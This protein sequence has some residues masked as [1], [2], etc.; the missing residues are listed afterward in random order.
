[1]AI[2]PRRNPE[3]EY[4]SFTF[5][6]VEGDGIAE[7]GYLTVAGKYLPA[8]SKG[9]LKRPRKTKHSSIQAMLKHASELGNR[10]GDEVWLM[11]DVDDHN[12]PDKNGKR[13]LDLVEEWRN[14]GGGHRV[15]LSTPRFEHWLLLHFQEYQPRPDDNDLERLL[16]K[17]LPQYSG[18]GTPEAIYE[19]GI[20]LGHIQEAMKRGRKLGLPCMPTH[21]RFESVGH[22]LSSLDFPE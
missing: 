22:L 8:K 4:K 19:K 15:A 5:V 1:M 2:K 17:W 10:R 18:H 20:A 6:V 13:A 7:R 3:S 9:R 14:K 21:P 11:L 16:K 12:V